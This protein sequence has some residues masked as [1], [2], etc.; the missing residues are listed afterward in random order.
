MGRLT[1]TLSS[2]AIACVVA[3]I[4]GSEKPSV[5]PASSA[6]RMSD[7]EPQ[8]FSG[9]A[10]CRECH[11]RFYK[12]WAP[13][14]HGRAMQSYSAEFAKKQLTAHKND[15]VIGKHRFRADVYD[16]CV[17]ERGPKG[18]KKYPIKHVMGGKNVYYFLTPTDRGRLQTLP[19]AY[20]VR[21]KAWF[22][23]AASGIRHFPDQ[24]DEAVHWTEP[25]YTF[26]TS[27]HGCHVSQL[28]TNYD[29]KTDT[30]RTT[31]AEPGINCETCHGPCRDHIDACRKAPKGRPPEDMKLTVVMRK[32]GFTAHQVDT[33]CAPCHA[34]MHPLTSRFR[35]GERYFDHY[36]LTTLEH[37]DFYPDGR[38]LGENYTYTLWRMNPCA[39]SGKLDCVHCHTS[40]GRYRHKDKPNQ[41]CLPCHKKRVENV[42]DHSHHP[43]DNKGSL[44]ISCHMPMTEFARM[45]RSD[46]SFLPPTPATTIAFKSP[47]ACNLCHKDKD[48]AWSDKH[49]G[50][51]HSNDYQAPVLARAKLID[52]ARKRDW[53]RLDDA[54]AYITGED[55]DEVT[56]TSLI[57][58]LRSC[59]D[60]R[61]GPALLEALKD[62]SPLVRSAAVDAL[63]E[64]LDPET[65]GPMIEA[66]RDEYR[67]VRIQTANALADVPPQALEDRDRKSLEN[68]VAEFRAAMKVRP[69]DSP[70]HYN[71]GNFHMR[72]REHESAVACF[73]TAARLDPL[74]IAPLVN[75]SLAYSALGKNDKAEASLRGALGQDPCN[76]AAN[77]NL[78]L[79]LAELGRRDEAEAAL[80]ASLKTDPNSAQ[81]AYNLGVLLA[82]D[83]IDEAIG[84]C[85]RAHELRP[86]QPK[87]ATTLA[88]YLNRNGD[89]DGAVRVLRALVR[90]Q[91]ASAD[92]YAMLGGIHEKKGDVRQAVAVYRQAIANEKLPQRDR[93]GFATR[94]R[95][96]SSR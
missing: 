64:R 19:L 68:A 51:W 85:R 80:T 30:Y 83:R 46:H 70:S 23:T 27:C 26:N 60:R 47:N 57:R 88:F 93:Y 87:Y 38:D 16:G 53:S 96:L 78:G 39:K 24:P 7:S 11:E 77:F 31:W 17:I 18:E 50:K 28:A 32:N 1:L 61:L 92:V 89:T 2:L 37:P 71:L 55:R 8:R 45:R 6:T 43:A 14:H 63:G 12:L 35:P 36:G 40:S 73:E 69:D 86:D 82:D 4:H 59:D 91:T 44:C 72:R 66:T 5:E 90:R 34:K 10:S 79:L 15:I 42:V 9:S 74:S 25:S 21:K 56:A 20:D 62:P 22:D 58:L 65:V 29:L 41:S 13:S 67:I 3:G 33:A 84:W 48:A 81:A 95:A 75:A 76:A 49:V 94:V 54:L 52:A